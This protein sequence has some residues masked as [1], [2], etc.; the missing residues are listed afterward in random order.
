MRG[1]TIAAITILAILCAGTVYRCL[2][3]RSRL[4]PMDVVNQYAMW[5]K[6]HFKLYASPSEANYRLEVFYD[7][8]LFVDR[9]NS[10]YE[11]NIELTGQVLSAPMYEL[12]H[13]ADLTEEEFK[14]KY[15][16]IKQ[17]KYI[18][19]ASGEANEEAGEQAEK[20][21]E[22]SIHSE[23]KQLK[24]SKFEIRVRDQGSC[25]SCWAFAAV[26]CAEKLHFEK[27]GTQIE[28]SIQELVDCESNSEGCVGGW[29]EDSFGYMQ[30]Y[31]LS[32]SSSYPYTAAE[33]TCRRKEVEH[34]KLQV[35]DSEFKEYNHTR[36][37]KLAE[38]EMWAVVM[39]MASGKFRFLSKSNDYYDAK[40]SG[41]CEGTVDHSITMIGASGEFVTILNQYGT[42]WGDNG[43][44]K[45]KICGE[46]NIL[47]KLGRLPHPHGKLDF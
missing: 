11:A 8:K 43:M 45:I 26:A 36:A 29:P 18:E 32:L 13:F 25:A 22:G 2:S 47:G 39:V 5:R 46:T 28:L 4:I 17:P 19:E 37:I 1:I 30:I 33:G 21:S 41:E 40:A 9:S 15:T 42:K 14:A 31:G 38:R 34:V 24:G 7:Q 6:D 10:E 27:T 35:R 16:G 23:Q 3:V 12:N 44:K 20:V